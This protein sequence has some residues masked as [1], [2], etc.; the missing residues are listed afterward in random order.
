MARA[1]MVWISAVLFIAVMWPV[2]YAAAAEN[3]S[4]RIGSPIINFSLAST[5]ERLINYGQEY[6]GRKNVIIT[7]FPAA[8]TPV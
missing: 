6:Y 3:S 4:I 7:F 8:Y 5:Q 1:L 2:N